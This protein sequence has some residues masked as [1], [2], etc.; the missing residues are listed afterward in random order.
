MDCGRQVTCCSM[1]CLVLVTPQSVLVYTSQ[2]VNLSCPF[3]FD[4]LPFLFITGQLIAREVMNI[5][6]P[7]CPRE[8]IGIDV[9]DDEIF[10]LNGTTTADEM[11]MMPVYRSKYDKNTGQYRGNP[12]KQVS[13]DT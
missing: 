2:S 7:S 13:W 12:R 4:I 6:E 10:T 5:D 9:S 1:C 11:I 8:I 3:P